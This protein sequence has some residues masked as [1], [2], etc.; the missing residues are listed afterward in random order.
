MFD[1]SVL[2]A[3]IVYFIVVLCI[4]FYFYKRSETLSDYLIGGR[5]LNPFVAALSAQA[6]DMSGWLL[7]G[8][9]GAIYLGGMSEVWIG[10]GLAIGA[11]VS[12]RVIAKRLRQYTKEAGNSITLPQF[13]ENR[14]RDN[15]GLLRF[16]SSAVI[17]VFFTIYVASGLVAGGTVFKA[18]FPGIDY[19]IAMLI[20]ALVIIGYTFTGGFHAVCWTDFFQGMLMAV[21]LVIVPLAAMNLLG[22]PAETIALANQ[23][24]PGFLS[25]FHTVDGSAVSWI[26]IVSS[27]AWGL[28]YLGMPHILVR[29]MAIKKVKMIKTSRR[30]AT[31]WIIVSL[32]FA[33]LLGLV[34][35]VFLEPGLFTDAAGAQTVFIVM[36]GR[37]FPPVV[38]GVLF[39]AIMA[40]IMS[41]SD[42]QLLVCS[43]AITNDIYLKVKKK[44]P[45][46]KTLLWMGR[47]SVLAI[48]VIGAMMALDEKS[49]IMALVKYAWGG[50]GAA[51]GPVILMALFWKRMT[52][53]GA[54]VGMVT[55][56]ATVILWNNFLAESTGLYELVPGFIFALA[57]IVIASLLDKKPSDE[58]VEE[59]E[60]SKLVE[61]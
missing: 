51:F 12:W 26:A 3:F 31:A 27:L 30:V 4:G 32:T 37:I 54:L 52:R 29:F 17:L 57:G 14:F 60:R 47:I 16:I 43:S 38:A 41:T 28:G 15:R 34:G 21:V 61:E 40:A 19:K 46:Q 18:I 23:V 49:S 7:M 56:F 20:G 8:L 5:S 25:L 58:I 42:S 39:S 6:S 13:F 2:I 22:G 48:A 11:Y 53:T 44:K 50:F 24:G 55:G 45:S 1:W 36:A 10:I 35:R 59:F 33:C 9:P